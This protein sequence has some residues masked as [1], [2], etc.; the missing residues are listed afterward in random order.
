ME[1]KKFTG[2]IIPWQYLNKKITLINLVVQG[3]GGKKEDGTEIVRTTLVRETASA[4]LLMALLLTLLA[5]AA[6]V[7]REDDRSRGR[8]AGVQPMLGAA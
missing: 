7:M 6:L 8:W 4:D 5:Y 2:I 3:E 1:K